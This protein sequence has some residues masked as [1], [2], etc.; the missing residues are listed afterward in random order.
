MLTRKPRYIERRLDHQNASQ[1]D[2][3]S[4]SEKLTR[5]QTTNAYKQ[6]KETRN[7]PNYFNRAVLF[8]SQQEHH[9]TKLL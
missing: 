4:L 8:L 7:P 5:Q 3:E 2:V 9:T 6:R 1:S